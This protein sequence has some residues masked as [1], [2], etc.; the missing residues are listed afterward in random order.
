MSV[1]LLHYVYTTQI[2]PIHTETEVT[3]VAC[4]PSPQNDTAVDDIVTIT[5]PR[6][7]L[8]APNPVTIRTIVGTVLWQGPH[9]ATARFPLSAPL[10]ITIDL[11]AWANPFSSRVTPGKAYTCIQDSGIHWKPTFHLLESRR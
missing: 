4:I 7:P 11:G 9:G 10:A 8:P 2:L 6:V 1:P 5:L 3:G